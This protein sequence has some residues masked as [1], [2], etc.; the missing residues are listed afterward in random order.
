MGWR[1]RILDASFRDVPFYFDRT[2]STFGRRTVIHEFLGKDGAKAQDLGRGPRIF[3]IAGYLLGEDYL[4]Q[5]DRLLEACEAKSG[6]GE[7]VHPYLGPVTVVCERITTNESSTE[8]NVMRINLRFVEVS[9]STSLQEVTDPTVSVAENKLKALEELK[10]DFRKAFDISRVP[11]N[12]VKEVRASV[13]SGLGAIQEGRLLLASAASY[14]R[15]LE[16]AKADSESLINNA[17]E[18][19]DAIVDLVTFGS[20]PSGLYP[21]D[22]SSEFD[23]ANEDYPAEEEDAKILFAELETLFTFAPTSTSSVNDAFVNLL[24]QSAIITAAGLVTVLVYDS[25]NEA[26][27]YRDNIVAE[28]NSILSTGPSV[29]YSESLKDLR[30]SIVDAIEEKAIYLSRLVK[31][32]FVESTPAL[33]L[34]YDLYGTVDY[35]QNIL[36][37]NHVI[38]NPGFVPG[39]EP[40]EVL[41]DV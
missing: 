36:D 31:V 32:T 12:K 11:L 17:S 6:P 27:E 25:L 20:F 5:R 14:G 26:E 33:V 23:P 37:R 18:M 38:D 13:N 39:G 24:K 40:I 16:T 10:E 1:E 28:I 4:E 30:T 3:N 2:N 22:K 21:T 19:S 35:E 29:D 15:M 34:S 7:L 8:N 41:I 9:D